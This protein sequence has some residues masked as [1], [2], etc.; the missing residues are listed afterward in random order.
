MVEFGDININVNHEAVPPFLKSDTM[1]FTSDYHRRIERNKYSEEIL[2]ATSSIQTI[3]IKVAVIH[4][5]RVVKAIGSNQ[6]FTVCECIEP[7][8]KIKRKEI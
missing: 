8:Y 6:K 3:Q 2:L 5:H 7:R 4:S 1:I